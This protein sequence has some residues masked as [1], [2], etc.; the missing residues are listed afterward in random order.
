MQ[1]SNTDLEIV[2]TRPQSSELYLTIYHP[3]TVMQCMVTGSLSRGAMNIPYYT[4][5]T[6]TIANVEAGMTLLVGTTVGGRELGK[7]RIRSGT[8]SQF[9]VAEN[10]YIDWSSAQHL[11]VQKY[12]E[13]WPVYPRIIND[14]NNSEDVIFYKDYDVPYSNQ[15]SILGAFPCAGTHRALF[16]GESTYWDVSGTTHLLGSGL[17]YVW[18]FE[19]GDTTGSTSATP[20][21]VQYNTPGDYVTK[22][23]VNGANGSQDITYRYVMVRDKEPSGSPT[24]LKPIKNWTISNLSG[25]RSQGG[26]TASISIINESLEVYDG[27]VVVLWGEDWYGSTNQSFGGVENT[28][29]IFFVGHILDG[30][31]QY[32]YRD[33]TITFQIGSVSEILKNIEG[34]SV[35]V[36]S[37]ASPSKWF[38]LL[39]MDGRRALYH[40]LKWHTTVLSTVDFQFIGT[41]QKI[42]Y[43]D[44]DRESIFDAVD[45]YMRGTLLGQ[46]TANRQGKLFAEVGTAFYTNPTGSFSPVMNIEKSD[47]AGDPEITVKQIIPSS[48]LELGGIAYSG[49]TT[50]TFTA[51]IAAAPSEVP[52]IRGTTERVQGLA[53]SGQSHL[54]QIVGNLYADKIYKYP[55]VHLD[56]A[57]NYKHLDI[58]PH[59]SLYLSVQPSDT[60]SGIS[61]LAPYFNDEM[62]WVYDPLNKKLIPSSSLHILTNGSNGGTIT[63]PSVPDTG[64][65]GDA[66]DF[67]G[68][69]FGFG[70]LPPFLS[71]FGTPQYWV[72]N[73]SL[74]FPSS[75]PATTTRSI[76][77]WQT[78]ATTAPIV[79]NGTGTFPIGGFSGVYIAFLD[80]VIH[81]PGITA[82]GVTAAGMLLAES[83]FENYGGETKTN[84]DATANIIN[85]T[86]VRLLLTPSFSTLPSCSIFLTRSSLVNVVVSFQLSLLWWS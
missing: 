45:N 64:G 34:F 31:I 7:I 13:H 28:S 76:G 50:G 86:K 15:N 83:T 77:A 21:W 14:P 17:S 16:T 6:G 51:H 66:G 61:L 37:K 20:G 72:G 3:Q 59:E 42:Q 4:V 24:Y 11:T 79:S 19:G 30:S 62:S 84:T 55:D 32:N 40:Y 43:F 39:D 67:G 9:I 48:Y 8:S 2:R 80:A 82:A 47:W 41:D 5:S 54:N 75:D 81:G 46:V 71:S 57:N 60:P 25:S 65:Y 44:S 1:L 22:L 63:I 29:K 27:D 36:E 26:Y 56:W 18:S 35:S 38:E 53:I 78:V 33:S 74:L 69:N 49:T 73:S 23:V 68:L 58:A 70:K 52:N 85:L 10:G 12:W